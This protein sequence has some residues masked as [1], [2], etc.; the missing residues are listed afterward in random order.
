[1]SEEIEKY[2]IMQS[3]KRESEANRWLEMLVNK[4]VSWQE[5]RDFVS[6]HVLT[7]PEV[8]PDGRVQPEAFAPL[9]VLIDEQEKS[10]K[11]PWEDSTL[12]RIL[13][14]EKARKWE[15]F[16]PLSRLGSTVTPGRQGGTIPWS[17]LAH[18]YFLDPFKDD[19][20]FL[21]I[22]SVPRT[23]KTGIACLVG[24]LWQQTYPGT[25]ILTNIAAEHS[26]KPKWVREI[27][28]ATE[29]FDGVA[30]ALAAERRWLWI[31]DDAGLS[32]LKADSS[33][34]AVKAWDRFARIVP[35]LLGSLLYVEQRLEG[36]T[37]TLSDFAQSHLFPQQPGFCLADMPSFKTAIRSIPKPKEFR[38]KTGESSY[39]DMDVDM[40]RFL[41]C[42]SV[43]DRRKSQA[44]R[45]RHFLE[46]VRKEREQPRSDY[47][48]RFQSKSKEAPQPQ[49]VPPPPVSP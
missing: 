47:S 42:F 5:V 34:T 41:A 43:E 22:T 2:R 16:D 17:M 14:R 37:S 33:K 1:M 26:P 27:F 15:S 46:R 29:L 23:G 40:D 30:D 20:G 13:R 32:W 7:A 4:A 49:Q 19:G 38:Y 36:V 24:E 12:P 45:I 35:K 8:M 25:E 6:A 18:A 21:T 9:L 39:I 48:G 28:S 3:D 11:Q 31:Y 10:G 44:E